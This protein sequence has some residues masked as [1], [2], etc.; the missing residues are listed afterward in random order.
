MKGS[1]TI[2]A[3]DG[4][5]EA[6]GKSPPLRHETPPPVQRSRS[7]NFKEETDDFNNRET[8]RLSQKE[9]S[10]LNQPEIKLKG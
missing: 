7:K 1:Q 5:S 8:L 9:L 3:Y 4:R 6:N 10:L 2:E